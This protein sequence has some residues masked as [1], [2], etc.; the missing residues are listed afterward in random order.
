LAVDV[1]ALLRPPPPCIPGGPGIVPDPLVEIG[2]DVLKLVPGLGWRE[3]TLRYSRHTHLRSLPE[4]PRGSEFTRRAADRTVETPK[5]PFKIATCP[6]KML[7][8]AVG[9]ND[10][11]AGTLG[12]E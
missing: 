6:N 11:L 10:L 8:R 2:Y 5:D 12:N 9:C 7:D 1:H 4:S 3:F